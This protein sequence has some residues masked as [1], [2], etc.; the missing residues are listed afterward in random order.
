[1]SSV[2]PFPVQQLPDDALVERLY[3]LALDGNDHGEEFQR[4]D[5]ECFRRLQGTTG[6][7]TL[8]KSSIASIG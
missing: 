1:M 3:E 6:G 5:A 4:L 2:M 8:V 7:L